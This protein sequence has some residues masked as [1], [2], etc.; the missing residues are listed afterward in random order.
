M[1]VKLAEPDYLIPYAEE[2]FEGDQ[3]SQ[4]ENDHHDEVALL[5]FQFRKC[6]MPHID[7]VFELDWTLS[8]FAK[9]KS[10]LTLH[11]DDR[12]A[13][14]SAVFEALSSIERRPHL[15][16]FRYLRRGFSGLASMIERWANEDA[17]NPRDDDEWFD[18]VA[19]FRAL[20]NE[21]Q[22]ARLMS[23]VRERRADRT[24]RARQ[25]MAKSTARLVA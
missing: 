10:K 5:T 9:R 12:D 24:V 25:A 16:P 20:R 4:E 11:P 21:I 13:M 7:L 6:A 15:F 18:H 3:P 14:I 19:Y 22:T 8:M 17:S 2:S 23:F 1:H